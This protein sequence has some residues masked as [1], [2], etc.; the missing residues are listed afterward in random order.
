[1]FQNESSDTTKTLRFL[2]TMSLLLCKQIGTSMTSNARKAVIITRLSET[3]YQVE[4]VLC[5]SMLP[6]VWPDAKT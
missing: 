2:S 1:M 6:A 3:P 4:P 5:L